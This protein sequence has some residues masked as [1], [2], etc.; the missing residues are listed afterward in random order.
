[1]VEG[2]IVLCNVTNGAQG[3]HFLSS[4][5]EKYI[6]RCISEKATNSRISVTRVGDRHNFVFDF[7]RLRPGVRGLECTG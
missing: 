4:S 2:M 3:R 6:L 7:L 1:M 5:R